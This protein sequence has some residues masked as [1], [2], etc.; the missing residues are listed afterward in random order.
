MPNH[1]TIESISTHTA[2]ALALLV[3]VLKDLQSK[4]NPELEVAIRSRVLFV[5]S[6]T[7]IGATNTSINNNQTYMQ[8]PFAVNC[9]PLLYAGQLLL[10]NNKSKTHVA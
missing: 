4:F 9:T 8:T 3:V 1:H 6:D 2:A 7:G 10:Y 5:W